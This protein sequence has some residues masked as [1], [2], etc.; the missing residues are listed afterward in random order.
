MFFLWFSTSQT[1]NYE[2]RSTIYHF[3]VKPFNTETSSIADVEFTALFFTDR[4]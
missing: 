3:Y 1:S 2:F 4:F